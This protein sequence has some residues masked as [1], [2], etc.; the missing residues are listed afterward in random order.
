MS[1]SVVFKPVTGAMLLRKKRRELQV[2]KKNYQ[3]GE[4]IGHPEE[5]LELIEKLQGTVDEVEAA[6]ARG[7]EPSSG[8][9]EK[10]MRIR[11]GW[12]LNRDMV[13]SEVSSHHYEYV[14]EKLEERVH[15]AILGLI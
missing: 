9:I 2:E 11:N 6:R 7:W 13:C 15:W 14:L 3:A 5:Q 12:V 1:A 4:F 10:A 8:V